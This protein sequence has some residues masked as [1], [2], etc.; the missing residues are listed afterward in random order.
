VFLRFV[1]GV[2]LFENIFFRWVAGGS[3]DLEQYI[4]AISYDNRLSENTRKMIAEKYL[5]IL[6]AID[7]ELSKS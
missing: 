7:K 4:L 3:K 1:I 5:E 6:D 2:L